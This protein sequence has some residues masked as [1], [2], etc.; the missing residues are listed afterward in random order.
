MAN[1][2]IVKYKR[3]YKV[4]VEGK[5]DTACPDDEPMLLTNA[6]RILR[7]S[8]AALDYAYSWRNVTIKEIKR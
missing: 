2:T 8:V 7:T 6:D 4:V 1:G 3:V 5:T